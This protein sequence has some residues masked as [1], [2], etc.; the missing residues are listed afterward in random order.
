[1]KV[2]NLYSNE[3]ELIRSASMQNRRA[4]EELY[5][6]YASKMLSVCRY[7]IRDLH[8]AEDVLMGGFLKAFTRLPQLNDFKKFPGWLRKIMVNECLGFIRSKNQLIFINEE[9]SYQTEEIQSFELDF[10]V[11]EVQLWIDQ[12]PESQKVIF[13]LYAI[14][15]YSH[16]E[17]GTQLNIPLGTSKGTLSRARKTLQE[18]I[19]T[20]YLK[21]NERAQS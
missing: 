2:R 12:L 6:K 14:E 17:I 11:E 4:Q 19:K 1:M 10:S 9:N 21:K 18:K 13:I 15:G 8:H 16:Q 7:Y 20:Y 3:S 5:Q